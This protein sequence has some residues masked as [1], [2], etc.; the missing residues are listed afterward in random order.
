MRLL[1]SGRIAPMQAP[2][3]PHRSTFPRP[4]RSPTVQSWP[5]ATYSTFRGTDYPQGGYNAPVSA[6][7]YNA[8]PGSYDGQGDVVCERRITREELIAEGSLFPGDDDDDYEYYEEGDEFTEDYEDPY[9]R[10]EA[11]E[12]YGPYVLAREESVKDGCLPPYTSYAATTRQ[13]LS[14]V[15]RGAESSDS[16][17]AIPVAATTVYVPASTRPEARKAV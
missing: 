17:V 4:L 1:E 16:E 15:H 8:V 11:Y 5:E 10:D 12:A 9:Q 14:H 3:P 2:P 7:H 13:R 6:S